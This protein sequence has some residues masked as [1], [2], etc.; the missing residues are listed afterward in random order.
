MGWFNDA[1]DGIG[2]WFDSGSDS[3]A[4]YNTDAGNYDSPDVYSTDINQTDEYYKEQSGFMSMGDMGQDLSAHSIFPTYQES[5]YEDAGGDLYYGGEYD[6][7]SLYKQAQDSLYNTLGIDKET[8]KLIAGFAGAAGDAL[9][10][11]N[12]RGGQRGGGSGGPQRPA[13]PTG[14]QL[15]TTRP[16]K[17]GIARTAQ[18]AGLSQ[19]AAAAMTAMQK[20]QF[21]WTSLADL[22][23]GT[24]ATTPKGQT[25]ANPKGVRNLNVKQTQF[26]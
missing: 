15:G 5:L 12:N 2:D 6:N 1:L 16:D 17:P 25:I 20:N 3:Y 14:R 22:I 4:N 9:K 21:A 26:V 13:T 10:G 24:G 19:R 11:G 8:A 18:L 7:R 23:A